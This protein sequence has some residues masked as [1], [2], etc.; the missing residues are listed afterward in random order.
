MWP[1]SDLT[2]LLGIELPIVQAPMAGATTPAL[3]A[4]VCNAGALGS[5]GCAMLSPDDLAARADELR[6]ATNRPFNLNFFVHQAPEREPE[7]EGELRARLAPF[8]EELGL[9]QVP[10]L[11]EL[12][13]PFDEET[14]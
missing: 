6:A 5:L 8:Y 4:A 7:A 10:A 1:R 9:G 3:A 12:A 2:E 14:L 13:K 11:A